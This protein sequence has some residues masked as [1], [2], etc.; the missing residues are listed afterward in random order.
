MQS[1]DRG[2]ARRRDHVLQLAGM[3]V[4]LEQHLRGAH[5]GLRGEQ[6]GVAPREPDLDA[7]IR[8]RFEDQKHVR[9]ARAR[10]AGDC[11]EVTLVE[12]DGDADGVEHRARGRHIALARVLAARHRGRARTDEGWR[13]RHRAHDA[14]AVGDRFFDRR[15]VDA[16]RDRDH[17]RAGLELVADLAQHFVHDL[18]LH[19]Q[20]DDVA[21]PRDRLIVGPDDRVHVLAD[22]VAELLET[23]AAWPRRKDAAGWHVVAFD[24]ATDQRLGHVT[25]TDESDR[26]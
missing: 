1:R 13:V 18:R 2:A 26:V 17:E 19:A 21:A 12:L 23:F 22:L 10:E 8:Q 6:L 7:G 14:H 15:G 11:I 20:H 3:L 9:G 24:E 25:G 5:H 4:G 16:R